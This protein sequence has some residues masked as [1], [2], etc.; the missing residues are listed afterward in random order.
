MH[1]LHSIVDSGVLQDPGVV[2]QLQSA[3]EEQT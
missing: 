2:W 3:D 1:I